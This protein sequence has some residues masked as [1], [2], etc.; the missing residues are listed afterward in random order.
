MRL[1][2]AL[3]LSLPAIALLSSCGGGGPSAFGQIAGSVFDADGNAVRDARV[4]LEGG[5]GGRETRTNSFGSYLLDRAGAKSVTVKAE[6]DQGSARY[7]GQ[8]VATVFE[9]ERTQSVNVVVY[10]RSQLAS[11]EGATYDRSG[12]RLSGVR[13]FV[14]P[15]GTNVLSSAQQISDS[16]GNFVIEG[17]RAD[18]DYELVANGRGY[19]DD[20]DTFRLRPGERQSLV[21]TLGNPVNANLA[22]PTNLGATAWTSP[23]EVTRDRQLAGGIEAVKT[24][25]D[26]KRAKRAAIKGRDTIGGNPVEIEIVWDRTQGTNLLGYGVYRGTNGGTLNNVDFLRDPLAEIYVDSEASLNENVRYDVALTSLN[27]LYPDTTESESVLSDV[28]SV[29]P[30]GDLLSNGVTGGVAP[31]FNWN[32]ADGATKYAVFVF[33]EYPRLGVTSRF[34][35]FDDPV[36]GSSYTYDGPALTSGATYYY[37]ILGT[38]EDGSART[39]SRIES[40]V[41]R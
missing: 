24:L 18:T 31:T 32:L 15:V 28:V 41:A 20:T 9:G 10:P 36:R 38:N 39:L 23:R 22:P 6:V 30:I 5:D 17:L 25:L 35:N 26:P 16:R 4:Y 12:N 33:N 37:L 40:F 3:F 11:I 34:N 7:F 1:L 14:R 29:T 19:G 2:S 8:N 13:V 27:T 21:V